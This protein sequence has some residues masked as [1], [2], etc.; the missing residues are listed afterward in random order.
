MRC[1]KAELSS[2]SCAPAETGT[3]RSLALTMAGRRPAG[4]VFFI[5]P[6]GCSLSWCGSST[7]FLHGLVCFCSAVLACVVNSRHLDSKFLVFLYL[8]RELARLKL[9]YKCGIRHMKTC[10]ARFAGSEGALP[11]C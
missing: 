10:S 6:P 3:A 4:K 5:P 9:E 7:G 11:L 1:D 8:A 2:A